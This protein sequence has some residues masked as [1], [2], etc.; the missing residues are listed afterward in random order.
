[1]H[2][3]LKTVDL[4]ARLSKSEYRDEIK[5]LR[6]QLSA[7]QHEVKNCGLPVIVIFEGWSAAGKGSKTSEIIKNLDPRNFT[8]YCTISPS[9]DE[10]RKPF[11]WRHWLSIPSKGRF[12]IYDRSWYPEASN[13][14]AEGLI[15]QAEA[16]YRLDAINKFERQLADDGVLIVKFFIHISQEE[17]KKRLDELAGNPDTAWRVVPAD[18]MRNRHYAEFYNAFNAMV[19]ATDSP[20]APW[21]LISGQNVRLAAVQIYKA[22][23]AAIEAALKKMQDT[24]TSEEIASEGGGSQTSAIGGSSGNSS[25]TSAIGGG[26]GSSSQTGNIDGG[27]GGNQTGAIGGGGGN[28]SLTGAIGGGGGSQTGAIGGGSDSSSQTGTIGGGGGNS[29][30]QTGAMHDR[31]PLIVMKKLCDIDLSMTID[32]K[33][34]KKRLTESQSRLFSLHNALYMKKIPLVVAYEG[35]DAAG[36][37]GNIKRL[38]AALDPRGYEVIPIAAPSPSEL[39]HPFLWRFWQ[40]L[41]KDGHIAIFDRTW[42]GRVLVERIE[43][44]ARDDEWRRAYREINEFE[45]D[46]VHWGAIVVKFWLHIDGGEQ[47]KRF[48]ARAQNPEKQWKIN[49]EDWRNRDKWDDYETA[50]DDMLQYT[51]TTYA[52]WHIIE[53]QDKRYARVK[54]IETLVDAIELRLSRI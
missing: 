8:T 47:L 28:S 52:P 54:A 22:L 38:T 48:N 49:S 19:L 41:P 30:S 6:N 50:V 11:L 44:F 17:Q 3:I 35:W 46:L 4:C 12:A 10:L 37:G 14:A 25:L 32:D 2:N 23:I 51:S 1:M 20:H 16:E 31:A 39:S 34:Y 7:L 43:G 24:H 40:A 18:Y 15:S 53:S 33:S 27:G 13:D 26:S 45:A 9:A 36:K 29:S 5:V 42:Y 21:R